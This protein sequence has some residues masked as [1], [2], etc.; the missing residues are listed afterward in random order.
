[1]DVQLILCDWAEVVNQK[2]YIMGAGWTKVVANQPVP[3]AVAVTVRVPWTEANRQ[4]AVELAL[5]T[6]DGQ[7]VVPAVPVPADVV[8]PPVRLEGKFE[9]G[10]PPGS[11]E[12]APLPTAFAFRL[13]ALP[14]NPGGY[15]LDLSIDGK[16]VATASFEAEGGVA[17][18]GGQP[19]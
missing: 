8:L 19:Q 4:H 12:G 2:L 7:R 9:V 5:F 3:M 14:L 16:T 13:P 18:I 17:S 11:K 15:R 10:R 6:E 1:M